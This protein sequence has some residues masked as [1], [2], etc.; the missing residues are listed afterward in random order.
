M[1]KEERYRIDNCCNKFYELENYFNLSL[2]LLCIA[3]T[4]GYFRKLNPEWEKV[5]GYNLN[6]LENRKFIDF[7]HPDDIESTLKALSQLG[8]KIDVLNFRNR[9][10]CKNGS[11]RWIEWR[12][13]TSK[14][15]LIYAVARDITEKIKTEE[16]LQKS[17]ER[18]RKI[19]SAITDYIYTVYLKNGEVIKTIH[20]PGCI[21]VTGYSEEEFEQDSYLWIKIVHPDDRPIVEKHANNLAKGIESAPIEHRIFHKNGEIRW[22]Q[23]TPVL[24][25]DEE[26]NL[27]SYDGLIRDITDRKIAEVAL[28]EREERLQ[29]IFKVAPIGIGIVVNRVF[30]DIN[31]CICDMTGY[32]KE[33][34]IGKSARI[35]YPSQEEFEYVGTEKYRQ[36]AEKGTG[37]VETK[38][39][40]KDGTIFDVLLASTPIDVNDL[41]KGVTF[42][43]L[44]ITERKKNEEAIKKEKQFT[45]LILESLPGL[46]YL[47]E[48]NKE[49]PEE[50][51]L[52]RFN[53]KH[54]TLTGYSPR[55]LYGMKIKDWFEPEVLKEAIKAIKTVAIQGEA[56]INLNLKIKDGSIIP[57]AFTGRLLQID[58]K[59]YF[60]GM[61][62]DISDFVNA[63]KALKE[64]EEKYRLVVE[65]ANDAIFIVQDRLI[66]FPNRKLME[67]S[68]YTEEELTGIQFQYF[69]HEDDRE[70][71]I[72]NH[73]KRLG[74]L[75]VPPVY[76]FRVIKKTGEVKWVEIS[77]VLI[78]WEDN[79]ATLNFLRDITFQKKLEEQLLHAQKLEAIGTLAGGIAHNFN[80]LLM[81]ILGHTSLMLLRTDEHHPFYKKLKII[82]KLVESGSELTKQL[83]GFARKGKYE[84]KPIDINE[85]I[86]ETSEMFI[87][88]K[89]EITLQRNLQKNLYIVEADRGQLEQVLINL[90]LNAWQAMPSGG[91]LYI[92]TQNAFFDENES[93]GYDLSP[94]R[95]V[96]INITDTGVGMDEDTL[97]RIFE[98]FFTTKG[99]SEGTGLGLA[100][101]YGIIKNHG[102]TIKVYS[103]KG[104]GTTFT[105]YLPS[106]E[107]NLLKE[108]SI[109]D[110]KPFKGDETI[111]IIDDEE[112]NTE[113][114]KELLSTL[115]Y[116]V[117]TAK[118]GKEAIKKYKENFQEIQIIILDLIMP[119][120][121]GRE[122]LEKLMEINKDIKVLLSSGY[123]MNGE[124]SN[125]LKLGCK[126]F[127]QK[128]FRVEELT[129]KIREILDE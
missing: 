100:S 72:S 37:F 41:K 75:E 114:V 121:S 18:Y 124:A 94:G 35:L 40:K 30:I 64:S 119:D 66:K 83:L 6:E 125:L 29:S 47:Y 86:I 87:S 62:L 55:E 78:T 24:H 126:G 67:I 28:K 95:Y 13:T 42:T 63:Q 91:N 53:K 108:H 49:F 43:A 11:Y 93:R 54:S 82:E 96:K 50:S 48:L 7:V 92:E 65:N 12:S 113:A 38:W 85:L 120:M 109:V 116:K 80:N 97:K 76:S 79:P 14:E 127:I 16:R 25:Y 68:G 98:P 123:S 69:I 4:D 111:L 3:D 128:P 20:G 31:Q 36:I 45:E 34:L 74:G 44:D 115:G 77:A 2:D 110:L 56:Q 104:Y 71:V 70:M 9:Y 117:L 51:H 33:E 58:D 89:K 118:S 103:E 15:G 73:I 10:R 22:V 122:T 59:M 17:E 107:I 52:V 8:Q 26:G 61:G 27:I 101:A 57:Y 19:T 81:G 21:A 1:D 60:F 84:T 32:S 88:T 99:L 106:L 90:Y 105:I 112:V 39:I 23:N 46:F 5:L 102:G 129:R